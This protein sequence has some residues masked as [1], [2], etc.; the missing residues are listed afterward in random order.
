VLALLHI[1]FAEPGGLAG[2]G[3]HFERGEQAECGECEA[4]EGKA[5]PDAGFERPFFHVERFVVD[6]CV[7]AACLRRDAGSGTRDLRGN[8]G[9]QSEEPGVA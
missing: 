3:V 7:V 6:W 5:R 2:G 4:Q 1:Q 9:R 8:H